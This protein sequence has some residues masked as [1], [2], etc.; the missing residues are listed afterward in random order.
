MT[1]LE[2]FLMKY[3]TFFTLLYQPEK[4][5]LTL[6]YSTIPNDKKSVVFYVDRC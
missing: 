5:V 4:Q 3:N 1:S 6:N 2:E